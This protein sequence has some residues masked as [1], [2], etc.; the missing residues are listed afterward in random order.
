[1]RF[2]I[3]AALMLFHVLAFATPR[4]PLQ[5]WFD[6]G[7]FKEF[8]QAAEMLA[9]EGDGEA[10]YLLAHAYQYGK[11]V[12]AD[13]HIARNLYRQAVDAGHAAAVYPYASMLMEHDPYEALIQFERAAAQGL[14]PDAPG[15]VLVTRVQLCKQ[16]LERK[17]CDVAGKAL[18]AD[19]KRSKDT[20]SLDDA[21]VVHVVACT[22]D[23]HHGGKGAVPVPAC[24]EATRLAEAGA[25]QGLPRATFNRGALA[26]QLHRFEEARTWYLRAWE[27]GQPQ[28]GF[29]L[30]Q[31]YEQGSGVEENMQE[32]LRWYGLAAARKNEEARVRLARHWSDA[33]RN[34][35][36]PALLRATIDA[37]DALQPHGAKVVAEARR[38]LALAAHAQ[39]QARKGASLA[40]L[41]MAPTLCLDNPFDYFGDWRIFAVTD[42]Q[43]AG[44]FDSSLE[45]VAKGS[46]P[47]HC[48]VLTRSAQNAM[49]AALARQRVLVLSW[50]G[51]RFVIDATPAKGKLRLALGGQI[52]Y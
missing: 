34:S 11:G 49:R 39:G 43:E 2:A 31:L 46:Q 13:P 8:Q 45:L 24:A 15:K 9:R 19:W 47:E 5:S 16:Q 4:P 25:A 32:A 50:P 22:L 20:A 6:A 41:A 33:M 37:L 29:M 12:E 48:I 7:R 44:E 52:M 51:R 21:I 36:D 14:H 38:R 10:S 26:F 42:L 27:R 1:M 3:I 17:A 40:K 18:L 28:A 35:H 30:G 23:W